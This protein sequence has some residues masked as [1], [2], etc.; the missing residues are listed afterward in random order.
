MQESNELRKIKDIQE[1]DCLES[2]ATKEFPPL[3]EESKV[4]SWASQAMDFMFH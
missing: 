4:L 1:G 2:Q 3:P